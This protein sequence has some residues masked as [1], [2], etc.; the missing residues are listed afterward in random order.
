MASQEAEQQLS[1]YR[2]R[3]Q[4]PVNERLQQIYNFLADE[5]YYRCLN[6]TQ[7]LQDIKDYI[8]DLETGKQ[9]LVQADEDLLSLIADQIKIHDHWIEEA[10]KI[11]PFEFNS[12]LLRHRNRFGLPGWEPK[13]GL[14]DFELADL[15]TYEMD[16]PIIEAKLHV[17]LQEDTGRKLPKQPDPFEY[18]RKVAKYRQ[19]QDVIAQTVRER[20]NRGDA[21][22]FNPL[23]RNFKG[24]WVP[25]SPEALLKKWEEMRIR[26]LELSED[27]LLTQRVAPR[28][29]INQVAH[30]IT[31]IFKTTGPPN[32]VLMEDDFTPSDMAKLRVLT[33]PST[34]RTKPSNL[35]GPY[36]TFVARV[37]GII[38]S[39]DTWPKE[40]EEPVSV[41][42]LFDKVIAK[43]PLDLDYPEMMWTLELMDRDKN[44]RYDKAANVVRAPYPN[45]HP[46]DRATARPG[47]WSVGSIG[48]T[49]SEWAYL[50]LRLA[51]ATMKISAQ[52][53]I[54][55]AN[56]NYMKLVVTE[57]TKN[58]AERVRAW[59]REVDGTRGNYSLIEIATPLVKDADKDEL[60]EELALQILQ[61]KI[62]EESNRN[63]EP[64][65][66]P[67]TIW[68]WTRKS[69][70]VPLTEECFSIN[71]WTPSI[72]HMGDMDKENRYLEWAR[73]Q[74]PDDSGDGHSHK[75]R[76]LIQGEPVFPLGETSK[77]QEAIS[78]R[79]DG[80][81]RGLGNKEF[82]GI[83]GPEGSYTR[84]QKAARQREAE[85]KAKAAAAAEALAKELAA[86]GKG[87][88]PESRAQANEP[89]AGGKGK[90]PESGE[91]T[92]EPA[93]GGNG[94]EPEPVAQDALPETNPGR[95][96]RARGAG[97]GGGAQAGTGA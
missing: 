76:K 25:P 97:G 34:H 33:E 69:D 79:I 6:F 62:V 1:T 31:T 21:F 49:L 74:Q 13:P 29:S 39:S 9:V 38:R 95:R 44:L 93:T 90:E 46:E 75:R 53:E 3:P 37:N 42:V 64:R 72:Q 63:W 84:K 82:D 40:V 12:P 23:P 28:L 35:R 83:Y 52:V 78:N 56:E 30:M 94:E 19:A 80:Q 67:T 70:R 47:K 68:D 18:T 66:T 85:E 2:G 88:E 55:H 45:N 8:A 22:A 11:T 89:A 54:A 51:R 14:I 36:L 50:G 96:A 86:G 81:L 4:P 26:L 10:T 60:T 41:T 48:V 32:D 61:E 71:R 65:A 5:D 27:L 7:K 43:G 59:E 17:T 58:L 87:K 92:Q 16:T 91:Q 77:Q 24:P 57:Y 15:P 20:Y 73:N